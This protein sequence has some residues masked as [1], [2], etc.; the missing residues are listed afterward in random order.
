MNNTLNLSSK[1]KLIVSDFDGIFTDNSIYIFDDGKAAKRINYKDIMGVSVAI[2]NGIDVAILSG[3]QGAAI[4]YLE[5]TFELAGAFQGIRNKLPVLKELMEK[6]NLKP[7]EVLYI[8]DDINDVECL[9]HAGYCVTVS[10][11]N[12]KVLAVE[13][14]QITQALAGSGAFR[15]VVDLIVELKDKNRDEQES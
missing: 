4:N 13:N 15:E 11:A 14:I 7:E 10:D 12:K 1:I 9:C 8:G 3:S 2:K 5:K 6:Y